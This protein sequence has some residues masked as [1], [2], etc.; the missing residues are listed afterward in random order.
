MDLLFLVLVVS[1]ALAIVLLLTKVVYLERRVD[2]YQDAVDELVKLTND[3]FTEVSNILN[4][5]G[6]E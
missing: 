5:I 2:A 1:F 4:K 6:G 3:G